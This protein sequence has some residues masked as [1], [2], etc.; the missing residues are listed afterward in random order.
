M[1]EQPEQEGNVSLDK[2]VIE[3]NSNRRIGTN[4]DTTDSELH[5]SSKHLSSGDFVGRTADGAFH[6]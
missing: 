2:R 4:L 6:Q 1:R 3:A 5:K